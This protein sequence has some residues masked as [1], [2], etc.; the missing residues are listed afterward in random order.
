MD[1]HLP[2][3][4]YGIPHDDI[5]TRRVLVST[6]E[7]AI[8]GRRVYVGCKGGLGRTGL[9]L[10]LAAKSLGVS[11][12]IEFIRNR[13]AVAAIETRQQEDYVTDFDVCD[14]VAALSGKS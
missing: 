14:V 10:A 13:Y 7:A 3:E 4:D 8:G 9:F 6:L 2:I 5:A 1:A 11:H 12:P